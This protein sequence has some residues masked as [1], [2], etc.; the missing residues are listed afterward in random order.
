MR[1]TLRCDCHG[2]EGMAYRED[3]R[4]VIVVRRH[5]ENHTLVVPLPGVPLDKPREAILTSV[6]GD[7]RI[8]EG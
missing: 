7:N 1:T 3:D 8:T 6:T 4:L 2:T 5:K